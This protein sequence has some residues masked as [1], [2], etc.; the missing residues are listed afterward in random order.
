MRSEDPSIKKSDELKLFCINF[1]FINAELIQNAP[2]TKINQI[3]QFSRIIEITPLRLSDFAAWVLFPD[4]AAVCGHPG[5]DFITS[6]DMKFETIEHCKQKHNQDRNKKERLR[7]LLSSK[8][9]DTTDRNK[10]NTD[11]SC[12]NNFDFDSR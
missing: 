11:S 3:R 4:E 10:H 9:H 7:N 2:V 5:I 1:V 8:K 12:V 6:N